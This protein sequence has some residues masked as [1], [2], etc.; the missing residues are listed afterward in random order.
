MSDRVFIGNLNYSTTIEELESF[1][2][3]VGKV[4]DVRI[5]T[6]RD[7]GRPRGFAF[8][9]FSEAEEA[10]RAIEELN[11]R[12]LAGR[13]LAIKEAEERKEKGKSRPPRRALEDADPE[14]DFPEAAPRTNRHGGRSKPR[15]TFRDLRGTKRHL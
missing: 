8:A 3:E 7:S 11:G 4:L 10:R 5:P 1:L 6:D 13:R 14:Y 2:G 15:G 12:E 9:K